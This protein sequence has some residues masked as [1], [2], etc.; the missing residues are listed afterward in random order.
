MQGAARLFFFCIAMVAINYGLDS[1][2]SVPSADLRLC[3]ST[4]FWMTSSE[5]RLSF[6]SQEFPCTP[7]TPGGILLCVAAVANPDRCAKLNKSTVG[8]AGEFSVNLL[9][10][11]FALALTTPFMLHL[12]VFFLAL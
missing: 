7:R 10:I 8:G 3:P 4:G 2:G 6:T 11:T 12:C 5:D 9:G 1:I